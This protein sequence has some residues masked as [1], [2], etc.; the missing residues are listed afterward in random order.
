MA[1]CVC[2]LEECSSLF[3]LTARNM[4]NLGFLSFVVL[5]A[6][7]TAAAAAASAASDAPCAIKFVYPSSPT[8]TADAHSLPILFVKPTHHDSVNFV[9]RCDGTI[10]RARVRESRVTQVY[11]DDTAACRAVVCICR[12]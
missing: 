5:L 6:A 2:W 3:T 1:V 4:R 9:V 11:G 10:V 12:F 8:A 7:A